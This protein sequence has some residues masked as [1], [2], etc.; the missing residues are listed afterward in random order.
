MARISDPDKLSRST[1]AS[2]ATPDGNVHFNL[3]NKTI[4]LIDDSLWTDVANELEDAGS[5]SGSE[6]GVDLQ[7]LYSF[8]KEQWKVEPDL[9]K[10][11]FPMVAITSEQFEF[12][13]GWRLTNSGDTPLNDSIPL[14]RNGGWS[15]IASGATTP[16]R[17]YMGVV[18]LG[19]IEDN[20]RVYYQ[21]N[22]ETK[23]DFTYDG[24]VNEPVLIFENAGDDF[25]QDA[26]TFSVFIRSAPETIL[27]VIT[28][29][30]YGKATKG[31]IGVTALTNQVFRFPLSEAVD[32]D[33]TLLDT[34]INSGGS[35][36]PNIAPYD[37]MAIDYYATAQS[38]A[39][40]ASSF[41]FGVIIDANDDGANANPT[42]AQIYSFVQYMLRQSIDISGATGTDSGTYIGNTADSLLRFVGPDLKTVAQTSTGAPAGGTGVAIEDFNAND[43]NDVQFVDNT[44]T[45]RAFPF[46]STITLQFNDN[47]INDANAEF[48]LFYDDLGSGNAFGTGNAIIVTADTGGELAAGNVEGFVHQGAPGLASGSATGSGAS[49]ASA[50]ATVLTGVASYTPDDLIGKVLRVTAPAPLVGSYFITDNDATTITIASD[51]P[52]EEAASAS[53]AYSIVGKSDGT[54]NFVY[55]YDGET[56]GGAKTAGADAD[57]V[58]VCVGLNKAQYVNTTITNGIEEVAS[59][60]L[61]ITSALERNYSDPINS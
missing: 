59:K 4:E 54:V 53:V 12:I 31:D 49:V 26:D 58:F 61:T 51:D 21:F 15:E 38:V 33:I 27:T 3:T 9:I 1:N 2:N 14:I 56:E 37:D 42:K 20:H 32:P 40:G 55:D 36:L 8:L 34:S 28:G 18:T 46:K 44:G 48:F 17:T 11:P 6:G 47:L 45:E 10:Y 43:I 57:V 50:G 35:G 19:N 29:F 5:V 16:S 39:V 23:V 22:S 24:P 7:T 52:F 25:T 41:N 30:T 13:E 60:T